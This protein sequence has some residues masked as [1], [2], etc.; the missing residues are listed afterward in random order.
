[1][2]VNYFGLCDDVVAEAQT[3]HAPEQIVVDNAQAFFAAP[4]RCRASL[5]SPRKFFGVPDGGFLH[6]VTPPRDY[7]R[8][9]GSTARMAHLT[10]R[11]DEVAAAKKS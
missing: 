8:D 11:L 1:V 5:Y 10:K 6:S 3:R 9:T 4:T 2:V 7:P